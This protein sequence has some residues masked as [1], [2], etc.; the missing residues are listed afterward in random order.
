MTIFVLL[1]ALNIEYLQARSSSLSK[2]ERVGKA[3][4][5]G[6]GPPLLSF[7]WAARMYDLRRKKKGVEDLEQ[8]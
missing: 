1:M 8:F 7:P 2:G 6:R 3:K 4:S 5:G